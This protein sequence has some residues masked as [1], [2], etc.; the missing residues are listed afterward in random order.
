MP[1]VDTDVDFEERAAAALAAVDAA[2][3]QLDR[4]ERHL[5]AGGLDNLAAARQAAAVLGGLAADIGH[6]TTEAAFHLPTP[7]RQP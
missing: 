7:I 4:C 2:R 6:H 5:C 3:D 1:G